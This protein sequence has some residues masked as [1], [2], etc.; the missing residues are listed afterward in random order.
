[1]RIEIA[2][3]F[4]TPDECLELNSW[5]I[6]AVNNGWT[7]V[8][9][10]K[11]VDN[12]PLMRVSTRITGELFEYPSVVYD[13]LARIKNTVGYGD[14]EVVNYQGRDGIFVMIVYPGKGGHLIPHRD[15]RP[16]LG[17]SILRCN[18]LSS[19]PD[20]GGVLHIE[21]IPVDIQEG[22][23]H[24]YLATD[25]EHFFEDVE[26]SKLRIMWIF[27]VCVSAQDWE[28]GAITFGTH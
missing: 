15:N 22:D 10:M 14:A 3:N 4:V 13:V 5:A 18:F 8:S 1:M 11:D 25:Y 17:Q 16:A 24:A 28:S 7:A 6:S 26:G 9:A 27:G 21:G 12:I 2:R 20:A 19:K 23:L